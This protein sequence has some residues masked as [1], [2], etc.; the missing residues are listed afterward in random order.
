MVCNGEI[1]NHEAIAA[2]LNESHTL[3]TRSDAEVITHLYEDHGEDCVN[4]LDGMFAFVLF[5]SRKRIFL[6]ARDPLGIKPLYYARDGQ[7]QYFASEAKA[8]RH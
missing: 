6:A 7:K 2:D 1:Y 3:S 4:L 8:L 5:D